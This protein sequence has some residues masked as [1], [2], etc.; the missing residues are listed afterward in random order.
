MD[1]KVIRRA[2]A[3]AVVA[4]L[5][6]ATAVF[7]DTVP[8]DGDFTLPGNQATIDLGAMGPGQTVTRS[9]NFSL[10]CGGTSH[11]AVNATLTIHPQNFQKPLEYF[12]DDRPRASRLAHEP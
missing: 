3:L 7:A 5:I 6:S 2:A 9:V 8:A 11:P 12:Y 1:K 10:V 4:F